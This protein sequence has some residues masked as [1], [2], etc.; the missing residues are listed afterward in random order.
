MKCLS[1]HLKQ[2]PAWPPLR[3][4]LEL[5]TA[6]EWRE[7]EDKDVE[8]AR[9]GE[10]LAQAGGLFVGRTAEEED[11]DGCRPSCKVLFFKSKKNKK[12]KNKKKFAVLSLSSLPNCQ[13]FPSKMSLSNNS[14]R[15][16]KHFMWR[17]RL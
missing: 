13:Y 4:G 12:K 10:T 8:R 9:G 6:E 3:G 14:K 16:F 1:T 2:Q 7:G 5:F 11:N 15:S 17:S